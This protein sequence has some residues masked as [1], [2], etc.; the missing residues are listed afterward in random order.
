MATYLVVL[1][2]SRQMPFRYNR[3]IKRRRR[4]P[5]IPYAI[6]PREVVRK[7]SLVLPARQLGTATATQ[8]YVQINN[9]IR[10]APWLT[11]YAAGTQPAGLDFWIGDST[12]SGPYQSGIVTYAKA[13]HTIW[14]TSATPFA[15]LSWRD[16]STTGTTASLPNVQADRPG[17]ILKVFNDNTEIKPYTLSRTTNCLKILGYD[18]PGDA[19]TS[20]NC[21]F[22]R[23]A[24]PTFQVYDHTKV[25]DPATNTYYST[26]TDIWC[27]T[28][29]K[30]WIHLRLFD[31]SPFDDTI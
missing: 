19:F 23:T 1:P 7:F 4:A 13:K 18:S 27:L 31:Q 15:L 9:P 10:P 28:K 5:R 26:A 12:S 3:R 29:I 20:T 2:H 30:F 8:D 17:T 24:Q 11:L 6:P 21:L 22:G 14:R 25:F 16:N